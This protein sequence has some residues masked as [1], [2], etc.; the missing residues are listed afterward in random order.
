M[1]AKSVSGPAL[2][3]IQSFNSSAGRL[4][5]G[6]V[7]APAPHS[8]RATRPR[9]SQMELDPSGLKLLLTMAISPARF[10]AIFF[11]NSPCW[12]PLTP[13]SGSKLPG[14]TAGDA[15]LFP[16]SPEKVSPRP[17]G[18]SSSSGKSSQSTYRFPCPSRSRYGKPTLSNTLEWPP[19][20]SVGSR[21]V[22]SPSFDRVYRM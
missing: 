17:L 11:M 3:K 6:I 8:L 15:K 19:D 22:P 9:M 13:S 1:K 2:P 16:L 12:L 21:K 7:R 20:I 18:R 14:T 4:A 5:A 10:T